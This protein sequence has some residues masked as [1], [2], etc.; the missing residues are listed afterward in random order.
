[1]KTHQRRFAAWFR[2]AA[3]ALA[4][5]FLVVPAAPLGGV[6]PVPTVGGEASAT[7]ANVPRL[8]P[9][10]ATPRWLAPTSV[11]YEYETPCDN[12]NPMGGE[13]GLGFRGFSI[14]LSVC[15]VPPSNPC[16][17]GPGGQVGNAHGHCTYAPVTCVE[18]CTFV[19]VLGHIHRICW[20]DCS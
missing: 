8:L 4:L 2:T 7:P 17:S 13:F 15:G 6:V 19:D 10:R 14:G 5:A 18:V 20:D 3:P 9:R 12:D 16:P 1:M 11:G